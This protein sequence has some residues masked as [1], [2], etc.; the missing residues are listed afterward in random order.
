MQQKIGDYKVLKTLGQ[1]SY[2]KVFLVA[3]ERGNRFAAKVMQ[4]SRDQIASQIKE[5][6]LQLSL[7]HPF[8]LKAHTAFIRQEER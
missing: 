3:D 4:I 8:L 6:I 7:E 1:G 5:A 2:G